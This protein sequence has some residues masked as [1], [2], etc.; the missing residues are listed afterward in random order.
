[1]SRIRMSR[2]L[3]IAVLLLICTVSI[4]CDEGVPTETV[5]VSLS[6]TETFSYATVGGDEE[7][8]RIAIQPK[9]AMISEIRRGA[10]TNWV[11]T[12]VY[13]P[14]PGYIGSDYAQLEILTGSDGASPPDIQKVVIEF[15]IHD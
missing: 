7:G 3:N 8:A 4:A 11:A 10:E 15:D 2:L 12:Y 1:M 13:K 9:H 5:T 6:N 14:M